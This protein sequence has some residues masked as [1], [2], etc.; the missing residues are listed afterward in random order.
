V[1]PEIINGIFAVAGAL[2]GVIGTAIVTKSNKEISKITVF[3]SSPSRLL[4]VEDLAK[5]DIEIKYKGNVVSELFHGEIAVQNTG[6][7]SLE[8]IEVKILPE[9]DSPLFDTEISSTN[10]HRESDSLTLI[11]QGEIKINVGFLNPNDRIVVSYKS[12]GGKAPAVV[13]RK[14]GVDVELKDE[15]VN[16]VPDIYAK[17]IFEIFDQLPLM[18]WYFKHISK[19]YRLY[20]DAKKNSDA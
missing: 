8:N 5:S 19:P 1:K 15:A 7:K 2:I 12:S 20:L 17:L 18:R 6:S 13:S 14:L 4:D 16:W 3:R 10:F 11:E 9:T